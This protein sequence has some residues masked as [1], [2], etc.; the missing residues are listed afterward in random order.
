[1]ILTVRKTDLLNIVINSFYPHRCVL[2]DKVIEQN[3]FLCSDCMYVPKHIS[4]DV[5]FKCGVRKNKCR[6][7]T[8]RYHFRAVVAPF[9]YEGKIKD[10]FLKFK[11]DGATEYAD[12]FANE[13]TKVVKRIYGNITFDAIAY[14]PTT[15][16]KIHS[17][18]YNQ[19][20]VLAN[21][22]SNIISVPI[23]HKALEK[24]IDNQTQHTLTREER[25]QNVRNAYAC[26]CDL[27]GKTVLLIDDIKSSGATLN[28]C[29]KQ[30]LLGG[31]DTVYCAV[32]LLNSSNS[33]KELAKST[34]KQYT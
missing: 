19:C 5:C 24:L 27:T 9:W 34:V 30:L 7:K 31:A 11:F 23:E 10:A 13:M 20:E 1:M 33:D 17:R 8:V 12:Y 18:G 14:V 32:A 16:K 25:V 22:I 29:A 4:S 6:C 3:R 28:E 21:K 26:G 15:K 2:C